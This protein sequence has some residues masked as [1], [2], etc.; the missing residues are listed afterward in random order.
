MRVGW[1]SI[2]VGV[3]GGMLSYAVQRIIDAQGEP[4]METVLLQAHIPYYWRAAMAVLHA[5]AAAT[6]A[7]MLFPRASLSVR[8]TQAITIGVF[9]FCSIAM[10]LVP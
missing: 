6:L 1:N 3:W 7:H 5:L 9:V 2:L 8:W 4:P 10:V